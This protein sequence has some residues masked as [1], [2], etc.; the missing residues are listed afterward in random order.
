[1]KKILTFS[2]IVLLGQSNAFSQT[3]ES[4]RK[5]NTIYGE[6]FGSGLIYSVNYDRIITGD[7]KQ[8]ISLRIGW[9][10]WGTSDYS[11]ASSI[12]FGAHFLIGRKSHFFD[13]GLGF[14]PFLTSY[15]SVNNDAISI[16]ENGVEK[17]ITGKTYRRESDFFFMA[18]PSLAYRFQA[19]KGGLFFK[20]SFSPFIGVVHQKKMNIKDANKKILVEQNNTEFFTTTFFWGASIFPWGGLSIGWTF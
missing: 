12:P 5:V 6:A 4:N 16:Y 1:M 8:P 3:E 14:T 7:K 17:I 15:H 9:G 19:S 2:F 11:F 20:V 18:N 13:I 10:A